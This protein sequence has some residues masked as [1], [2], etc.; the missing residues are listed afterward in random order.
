MASEA[1][2]N[3]MLRCQT[4]NSALNVELMESN[5]VGSHAFNGPCISTPMVA[6]NVLKSDENQQ[7]QTIAQNVKNYEEQ[8]PWHIHR[9]AIRSFQID[10]FLEQFLVHMLYPFSVPYLDKTYGP[11]A[12]SIQFLDVL[13]RGDAIDLFRWVIII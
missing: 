2:G 1:T 6:Q 11:Q 8:F 12:K 5:E 13:F 4:E 3:S 10:T 7:G 9:T